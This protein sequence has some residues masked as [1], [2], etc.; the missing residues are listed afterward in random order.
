MIVLPSA[1]AE[2]LESTVLATAVDKEGRNGRS[3]E[4]EETT[5]GEV[6]MRIIRCCA[7]LLMLAFAAAHA[8]HRPDMVS[9]TTSDD[10][11]VNDDT[12]GG[13]ANQEAPCVAIDSAG[14]IMVAWVDFRSLTSEVYFQY[15]DSTGMTEGQNIRINDDEGVC[16]RGPSIAVNDAGH[17][18]VVWL[19][20]GGV[21][22]QRFGPGGRLA[23]INLQISEESA[24]PG[25]YG[26]SVATNTSGDIAVVWQDFRNGQEDVYLQRY[27]ATGARVGG[28]TLVN[29]DTVACY[30][31]LPT[32][33]MNDSGQLI[34]VW[35]DYRMGHYRIYSQRFDKNGAQ[36]GGNV[37]VS[38]QLGYGGHVTI[39]ESGGTAVVWNETYGVRLQRYNPTGERMGGNHLLKGIYD[40]ARS[41]AWDATGNF[42]VASDEGRAFGNRICLWR[43]DPEGIPAG[44]RITVRG[45]IRSSGPRSAVVA[46]NGRGYG[47]VVWEDDRHAPFPFEVYDIY[48]QRFDPGCVPVGGNLLVNDDF[49][50]SNQENPAVA[51]NDA[52]AAAIVW[53]DYRSGFSDPAAYLA[54]DIYLQLYSANGTRKGVNLLVSDGS[55]AWEGRSPSVATNSSGAGVVVW[56]SSETPGGAPNIYLRSFGPAGAPLGKIVKVSDTV[57]Y[58]NPFAVAISDSGAVAVTWSTSGATES[59]YPHKVHMQRYGAQGERLGGNVVVNDFVNEQGGQSYV[60]MNA[61]GAIAV[62]WNYAFSGGWGGTYSR[63][64]MQQF[65]ANG[66]RTGASNMVDACEG[67]AGLSIAMNDAGYV[68]VAWTHGVSGYAKDTVCIRYYKPDGTPLGSKAV[69][70]V[71]VPSPEWPYPSITPS[72]S[73]DDSGNTLVLWT[74]G[75]FGRASADIMGQR[76]LPFGVMMGEPFRIQMSEGPM[77]F[78]RKIA[79]TTVGRKILCAWEDN[80]RLKGRD[81]YGNISSFDWEPLVSVVE[82]PARKPEQF[83]LAQNY[84][85]PFNPSTTI[86]YELPWSSDVRLS[87]FDMLGREV[88]VLVNE[89][90]HAGVYEVKFDGSN[91]SSGVYFYRLQAGDFVSTK[92][93]LV[94][95]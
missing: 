9:S 24:R 41:V 40:A 37:M 67:V 71:A 70:A 13:N 16:D 14:N 8:Q 48:L 43:F 59:G 5:L 38:D 95:K 58:G 10:F 33:A 54:S 80:R 49:G 76:L 83:V 81:I 29:D 17:G 3:E 51:L 42:V 62:V 87:V 27:D 77:E 34:V 4:R 18:A 86:K 45:Q 19:H 7:F 53:Q 66:E 50:T 36:I 39:D 68:V 46:L 85:N 26:L 22:L 89:R 82:R 91:L 74:A 63:I 31:Y 84:P 15:F 88:S 65:S 2:P 64:Y 32:V 20:Q 79:V 47:A 56:E 30:Q 90:R 75:T 72:V 28:N 73:M 1:L 94:L 11:L 25:Q 23:G 21:W 61:S 92:K 93:V 55:G 78:Q 52:G 35:Q 69:V 60:A 57:T 12:T 44:D 6:I